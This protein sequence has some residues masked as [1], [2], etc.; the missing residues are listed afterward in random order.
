MKN[1]FADVAVELPLDTVFVY[2]IPENLD[3]AVGARVLVPFAR[4]SVT[5]YVVGLRPSLEKIEGLKESSVKSILDSLDPVPLFGAKRL[6]FYRWLSAYY[7]APLGLVLSLIHP[8]DAS[9]KSFRFISITDKGSSLLETPEKYNG[10]AGDLEVLNAVAA[11]KSE[12]LK[13]VTIERRFSGKGSSKLPVH[14]IVLRLVKAG[15]V[16]ETVKLKSGVATK[17]ESFVELVALEQS[18]EFGRSPLQ[19]SVY[20]YLEQHGRT[21]SSL[22]RR[23]FGAVNGVIKAL[24][25]KGLVAV[26]KKRVYRDPTSGI[27][28]KAADHEPNPEQAV[29]IE[30]IAE[31]LDSGLF[32]PFLLYGVTGSGKTLVYL[33]AL[34]KVVAA[35]GRALFLVPETALAQWP[36]AYLAEK[37]PGRVAVVHSALSAGERLD[38]WHRIVNGEALISS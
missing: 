25:K 23:E 36:V 19:K 38:E 28:L 12:G 24:L 11:S 31:G 4:R 14:S 18:P 6:K 29:A 1:R 8:P 32:S 30:R 33:K 16:V 27:R 15:L 20:S 5:G 2:S 10:N 34:E 37:F 7:F 26:T 22:L 3:I 9:L 21:A 17:V 35:K 13:L